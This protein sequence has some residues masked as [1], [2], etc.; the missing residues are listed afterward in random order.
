[1]NGMRG[2]IVGSLLGA[3]LLLPTSGLTD[4]IG[5]DDPPPD[6][7]PLVVSAQVPLYP[8]LLLKAKFDGEVRLR[9]TTDGERAST[10]TFES[11]GKILF[12]AAEENVRTWQFE[13]HRPTTFVAVFSYKLLPDSLCF[14]EAPTVVLHLPTE[15][16]VTSRGV[17]ICEDL[18]TAGKR[19]ESKGKA[20]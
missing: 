7:P 15:V 14:K 9:V 19:G 4:I 11:G 6:G 13:P 2:L 3:Q 5:P 17:A 1:M 20:I 18:S 10:I 8:D 12:A 16:E